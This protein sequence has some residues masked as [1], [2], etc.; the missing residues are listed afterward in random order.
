M[1]MV[2]PPPDSRTTAPIPFLTFLFHA[3][4][5]ALATEA[6]RGVGFNEFLQYASFHELLFIGYLLLLFLPNLLHFLI[7]LAQSLQVLQYK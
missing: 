3:E 7:L 4:N 1:T 6:V 5:D 2:R